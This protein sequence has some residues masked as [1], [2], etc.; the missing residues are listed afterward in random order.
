MN[1]ERALCIFKT[2]KLKKALP[3]IIFDHYDWDMAIFNTHSAI[4]SFLPS[5]INKMSIS[6]QKKTNKSVKMEKNGKSE[7]TPSST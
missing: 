4:L 5:D 6:Q 7:G 1:K 2:L 3:F